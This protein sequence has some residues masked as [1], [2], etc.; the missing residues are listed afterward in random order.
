MKPNYLS[1]IIT[2][3]N[4]ATC[5]KQI[6]EKL[7]T[8][9]TEVFIYS[10]L[11]LSLELIQEDIEEKIAQIKPEKTILFTDLAGGSCWL[12]ANRIK[13]NS[14]DISVI[15][16]TN[17]PLLVSYHLNCDK[18]N[19]NDLLEKIVSDGQKGVILK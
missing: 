8:P 6:S 3:G 11:E 1:C 16:G 7:I 12:V 4:F 5:L 2:H 10:N 17:V 19:W 18:L 15:G 9:A 13:K 14:P